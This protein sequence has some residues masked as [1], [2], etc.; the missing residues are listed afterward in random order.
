[1]LNCRMSLFYP[2]SLSLT[3]WFF[4]CFFLHLCHC[5]HLHDEFVLGYYFPF[6][7][8][9]CSHLFTA[10]SWIELSIFCQKLCIPLSAPPPQLSLSLFI[11]SLSLSLCLPQCPSL[12]LNPY[13]SPSVYISLSLHISISTHLSHKHSL[14]HSRSCFPYKYVSGS[15]LQVIYPHSRSR[16]NLI[17]AQ[18]VRRILCPHCYTNRKHANNK[19]NKISLMYCIY[20]FKNIGIDESKITL[21]LFCHKIRIT[22]AEFPY[23]SRAGREASNVSLLIN[24][25][26]LLPSITQISMLC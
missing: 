4:F 11:F 17:H 8:L 21:N 20:I 26:S 14:S 10:H 1:M 12:S 19:M 2:T 23:R 16:S 18:R 3:R 25:M 22:V 7:M 9:L 6:D 24:K 15:G 13:L 5:L